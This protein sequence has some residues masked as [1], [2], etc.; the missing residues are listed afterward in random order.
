MANATEQGIVSQA[1]ALARDAHQDPGTRIFDRLHRAG[2]GESL[3]QSASVLFSSPLIRQ[4]AGVAGL[5]P[6]FSGLDDRMRALYQH[7]YA[8]GVITI[9]FPVGGPW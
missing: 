9:C 3:L 4:L 8:Q 5:P 2:A 1:A 6:I 7:R